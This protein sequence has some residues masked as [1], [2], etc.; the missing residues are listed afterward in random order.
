M[1]FSESIQIVFATFAGIAAATLIFGVW[2]Y[3]GRR[4]RQTARALLREA[5][6]TVVFL[7][8]DDTLVNATPEARKLLRRSDSRLSDWD[9]LITLLRP[10]F[11]HIRSQLSNLAK[12]G[13]DRIAATDQ[14]AGFIEAELWEGLARIT[15]S[16]GFMTDADKTVD[17]ITLEAIEDELDN[18]RGLGEAA[19]QLIWKQ[20]AE[21]VVTWANRAYLD[22]IEKIEPTLDDETPPWPPATLF[23][24][25]GRAEGDAPLVERLVVKGPYD[26]KES[27]FDVTSLRRGHGSIHFGVD[28]NA[29]VKAEV[30]QKNFVQTLAKTFAQLSIGLAVFDRSRRLVMFNP[31]LLDLTQLPVEFLSSRPT[32][33]AILDRMRE[34]QRLPEPRNYATWREELS[35]FE[36]QAAN[37][38]YCENWSLLGGE[39]LRVTGRPHPDG[40]IAFLFED[41]SAEISLTRRF[42]SQ[43]ELGQHALDTIDEAVAV[44]APSGQMT[45]SNRPY[46]DLWYGAGGGTG[47]TD[48]RI[49]Q[50]VA[51]WQEQCAPTGTW[52]RI[53]DFVS[54]YGEREPAQARAQLQD[55]RM[56]NCRMTPLPGGSALIG[57]SITKT[58]GAAE[59]EDRYS[60]P[61]VAARS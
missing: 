56:L 59:S 17:P 42:R 41:I 6:S 47:L 43:V 50:E 29:A 9:A 1:V 45:L 26:D 48:K 18:L 5:E 58:Q 10:R 37:G 12:N 30:A 33:S 7:F 4:E 44:F 31:S 53:T 3:L 13:K 8:D 55:G 38:T 11:P 2:A 61:F 46:D 15:L 23:H 34:I 51:V 49:S 24:D 16:E 36:S 20:D 14:G 60:E 32:L 22:V 19:P 57:F 28:A 52:A 40:A 39:T 54:A 21:G 25:I 27:W 35:A